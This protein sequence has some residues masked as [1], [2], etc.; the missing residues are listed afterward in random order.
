MAYI[1]YNILPDVWRQQMGI[2]YNCPITEII[3][4]AQQETIEV[5]VLIGCSLL[6][7]VTFENESKLKFINGTYNSAGGSYHGAF[8]DLEKLEIVDMS[9]CSQI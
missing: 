8:Y 9:G 1:S 7:T 6:T 2:F 5:N 3:F 4:P